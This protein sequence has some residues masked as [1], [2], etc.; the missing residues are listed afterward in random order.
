MIEEQENPNEEDGRKAFTDK[1]LNKAIAIL[2]VL[3]IYAVIFLKI[4]FIP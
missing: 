3:A 2:F 4:L 1:S